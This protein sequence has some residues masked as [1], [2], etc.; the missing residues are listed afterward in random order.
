MHELA[1]RFILPA[2]RLGGRLRD[3]SYREHI[4]SFPPLFVFGLN[5]QDARVILL[6]VA[7]ASCEA[8]S[9]TWPRENK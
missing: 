2:L 6:G 5:A 7:R 8:R 4:L 3:D 9:A 1:L